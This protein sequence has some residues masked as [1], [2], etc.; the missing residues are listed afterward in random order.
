[1]CEAK[2]GWEI[3][4]VKRMANA[5]MSWTVDVLLSCDPQSYTNCNLSKIV[6]EHN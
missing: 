1:M 3:G 6:L 2:K 4:N 5:Q